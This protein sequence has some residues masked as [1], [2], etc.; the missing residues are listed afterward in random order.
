MIKKYGL[1]HGGLLLVIVWPLYMISPILGIAACLI[2]IGWFGGK[3][4][5]EWLQRGTVEWPD[6]I[7][8]LVLAGISIYFMKGSI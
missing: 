3:E 4:Y 7:T 5:Q 8:P 6:I 1:H 2:G